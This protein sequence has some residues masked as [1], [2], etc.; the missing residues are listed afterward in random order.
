MALIHIKTERANSSTSITFT[1]IDNTYDVYEF[2]FVNIHPATDNVNFTFQVN[3]T[4]GAD[5]NDSPITSTFFYNSQ[6]ESGS[7]SGPGYETGFDLGN[8]A[9]FQVLANYLGNENDESAS[10]ILT[11]YSPASTTYMKNF[12]S[13]IQNVTQNQYSRDNYAA[14]YINDATAIDDINFKMSSGNIDKGVIHMYG[15]T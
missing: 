4:D 15:V 12:T 2:H 3:P 13:R 9:S 10:G 7:T 11:L 6:N 14:G 5:F 1:G 8:A